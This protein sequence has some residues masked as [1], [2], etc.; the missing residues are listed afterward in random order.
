[1]L[2]FDQQQTVITRF[3]PCTV[4]FEEG[5][6]WNNHIGPLLFCLTIHG[7]LQCLASE[8]AIDYID[9]LMVESSEEVVA[10]DVDPILRRGSEPSEC[11]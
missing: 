7:L 10:A 3:G 4:L 5:T 1:M 2:S 9:N 6:Q 8:L 11:G